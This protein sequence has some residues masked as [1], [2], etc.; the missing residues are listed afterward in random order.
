MILK[1]QARGENICDVSMEAC[2]HFIANMKDP[3]GK[4]KEMATDSHVN[5]L[6]EGHKII[7]KYFK[8]NGTMRRKL[9]NDE[10]D[11]EMIELK[12]DSM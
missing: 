7:Y 1:C 9:I 10:F 5:G 8:E 2:F 12:R 6:V 11:R 4:E 3:I